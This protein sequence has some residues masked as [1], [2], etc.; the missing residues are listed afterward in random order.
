MR[1]NSAR[2]RRRGR[3]GNGRGPETRWRLRPTLLVLED[4]RLLSTFHGDS[5]RSTT[6]RAAAWS[7]IC[8]TA[9]TQANAAGGDQTVAFDSTDFGTP[10]DDHLDPAPSSI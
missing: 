1:Y 3:R 9:I 2:D 7:A 6:V 4:R 5:T 8:A 10:A